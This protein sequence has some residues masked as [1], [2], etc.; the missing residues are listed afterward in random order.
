MEEKPILFTQENILKILD[1]TKTQTRRPCKDV[2]E[3]AYDIEY[4]YEDGTWY[5]MCGNISNGC[6]VDWVEPVKFRYD[7][8]DLLWVK[9]A[10]QYSP[11]WY[12][13]YKADEIPE[14]NHGYIGKIPWKSPLFMPKE[15]ARIWLEVEERW[16]ERVQD[17][18]GEDAI[19]EGVSFPYACRSES[20]LLFEAQMQYK[21]IW[22]SIYT[23]KHK[24]EFMW[25][26]N[27]WVEC[28]KF[29][30]GKK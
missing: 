8:G 27:P 2:P 25:K 26:N 12:Y 1:G 3:R 24:P 5:W 16:I 30:R 20:G 10:W 7:Y 23:K 13:C 18:S 14:D 28:Y 19:A 15:A 22:N 21:D 29:R 4:F 17:I 9:E 6:A 11:N